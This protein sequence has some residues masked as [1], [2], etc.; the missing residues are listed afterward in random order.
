MAERRLSVLRVPSLNDL[1]LSPS[2][3]WGHLR[4]REEERPRRKIAPLAAVDTLS[5]SL[6]PGYM[7]AQ[8]FRSG[9]AQESQAWF[10]TLVL[11]FFPIRMT[12]G[13]LS[14]Q[15]CRPLS[16]RWEFS[17]CSCTVP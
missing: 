4:S 14:L 7:E 16:S 12:V 13:C 3:F 2:L 9:L 5:P 8:H 6:L 17:P 10:Q 1:P 15:T 11:P